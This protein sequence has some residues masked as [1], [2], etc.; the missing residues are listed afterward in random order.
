MNDSLA[1]RLQMP[2][3]LLDLVFSVAMEPLQEHWGV[4][5]RTYISNTNSNTDFTYCMH[6]ESD[7]FDSR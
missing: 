6:G 4:E 3:G 2:F 7:D 5:P 1:V